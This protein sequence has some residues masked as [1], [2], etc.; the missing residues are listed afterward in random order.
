MELKQIFQSL[1]A[2]HQAELP[3]DL[4]VRTTSIRTDAEEIVTVSGVRRCGKSSLLSLAA[5]ALVSQG[6]N[7]ERILMV[8]FDDERFSEME[9]SQM[10][11]ILQAYR[12]MYPFQPLKDIYM[13]FDEIQLVKGWELFVMRVYKSYCKHIFITGSTS[14]MLS[15]EMASAL[16]G[17]PIEIKAFPLSF[18]EYLSFNTASP[19][20]FTEEGVAQLKALFLNYCNEGGFPQVVLA[21]GQSEKTRILQNYFNTMLFRDMIEHYEIKSQ[22]SVVRYFLKRVMNNLT[23]P[24]SIN[25]IYNDIKSQ[26]YKVNKDALY[27]WIEY[28]CN[29]FLFHA[30]PC[31]SKSLVKE[32][33][34]LSK[35]YVCDHGLRNAVLLPQSEDQGKQL[36]NIVYH[37]I[38]RNLTSEDRIFYYKGTGE[39]DF[40]VQRGSEVTDLVQVCWHLA[41]DNIDREVNGLIQASK[42]TSCTNCKI[43]TFDQTQTIERESLQISVIPIWQEGL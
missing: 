40:V 10:D 32:T 24:T 42:A 22:P 16:R 28:A 31:Y 14:Q 23:K 19:S 20:P 25:S 11:D 8:G 35:Y 2:M 3:Y 17:W 36:E 12:E 29:I 34:S 6:V 41:P 1:I 33:S 27:S 13:F 5:N 39:C 7:K 4:R 43:I 18:A 30:V 15:A 37:T 38:M 26:G 21:K 9:I